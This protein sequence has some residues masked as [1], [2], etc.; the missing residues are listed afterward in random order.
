VRADFANFGEPRS[1]IFSLV[2]EDGA[3]RIDDITS[4]LQP[5]WTLSD[6]LAGTPAVEEGE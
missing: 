2:R 6:I 1:I 4:T 5:R 3:W